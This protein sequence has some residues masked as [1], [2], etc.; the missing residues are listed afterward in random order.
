MSKQVQ[1]EVFLAL[2]I[3]Q[4]KKRRERACLARK[5]NIRF[6]GVCGSHLIFGFWIPITKTR[7]LITV[8]LEIH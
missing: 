2:I 6:H 5:N 4:K 8:L 1:E 3:A 7:T